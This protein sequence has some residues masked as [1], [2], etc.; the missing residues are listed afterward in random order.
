RAL[1]RRLGR[2]V[3][4]PRPGTEPG[5]V[6]V[7][8]HGQRPALGGPDD[9]A[10]PHLDVTVAGAAKVAPDCVL[11][12]STSQSSATTAGFPGMALAPRPA[13]RNLGATS[14]RPAR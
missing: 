3:H 5:R 12:L 1:P 13:G 10:A 11:G 7:R 14:R 8:P 2:A 6:P 4:R 9:R